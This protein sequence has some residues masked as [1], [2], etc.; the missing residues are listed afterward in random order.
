[1]PIYS[2]DYFLEVPF[3]Q[4]WDFNLYL[5]SAGW[6]SSEDGSLGHGFCARHSNGSHPHA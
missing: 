6:Q 4:Y 1:M 5:Y 3:L 2:R